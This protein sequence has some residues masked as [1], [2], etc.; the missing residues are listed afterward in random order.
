MTVDLKVRPA[1]DTLYRVDLEKGAAQ[2]IGAVGSGGYSDG[3]LAFI[4]G[5]LH[6]T[7]NRSDGSH[8]VRIDAKTGKG[9]DIGVI[10]VA[11]KGA[12]PTTPKERG[13]GKSGKPIHSVWGLV[14]DGHK[15][16]ALT[17]D[18]HVLQLDPKTARATPRFRAPITFYG[19]CPMLRL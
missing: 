19:S 5:V 7:F 2:P 13:A 15:T 18:G 14:W 3:D 1:G 6:G 8:L 17:Q 4:D 11:P 10:H 12:A 16:W 9:K